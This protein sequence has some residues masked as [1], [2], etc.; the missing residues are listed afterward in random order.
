MTLIQW[1]VALCMRYYAC[2]NRTASVKV[3]N[4]L[5]SFSPKCDVYMQLVDTN[6][7]SGALKMAINSNSLR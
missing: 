3:K 1:S 4:A 2:L 6:I 5:H 7:F